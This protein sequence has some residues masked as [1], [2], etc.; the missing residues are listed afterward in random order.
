MGSLRRML[1]ERARDLRRL[2]L[3]DSSD[4]LVWLDKNYIC[5]IQAV[6]EPH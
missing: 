5:S 2:N 3:A 1:G 6:G 4:Y